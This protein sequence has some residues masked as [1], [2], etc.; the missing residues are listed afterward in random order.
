[1]SGQ[2]KAFVSDEEVQEQRQQRQAQ[3]EK[4]RQPDDPVECPEE[5]TRSLYEQLQANKELKDREFEEETKLRSSVKGLDEDEVLFLN[6]VSDRQVQ[7]EKDRNK[8]EKSVIE[9]LKISFLYSAH[10]Q[11][12]MAIARLIVLI[13]VPPFFKLNEPKK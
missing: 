6:F 12:D 5:E 11:S 10:K 13:F 1:M 4:V 8:E 9:E 7:L 2:F 3:W